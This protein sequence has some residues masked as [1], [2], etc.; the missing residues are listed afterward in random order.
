MDYAGVT[1]AAVEAARLIPS[2]TEQI[3]RE[4]EA[5]GVAASAAATA[6]NPYQ[7]SASAAV[8]LD[9]GLGLSAAVD[10]SGMSAYDQA[11]RLGLI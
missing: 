1:A 7:G 11:K 9:L 5:F 6:R 4:M 8:G 2:L 10:L 3:T